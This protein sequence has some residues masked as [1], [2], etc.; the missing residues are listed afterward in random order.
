MATP[1]IGSVDALIADQ[2]SPASNGSRPSMQRSSVVLPQ[3]DGP[4]MAT[5]S[6]S[7]DVEVDVAEHFERAVMLAQA[8][9]ANA[10]ARRRHACGADGRM[11]DAAVA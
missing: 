9:D 6:R 4:T 11:A 10:R 7:A 5:I 8:L 1:A 2:I 3:P